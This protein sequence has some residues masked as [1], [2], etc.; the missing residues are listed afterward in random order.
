MT[1]FLLA[2][3]LALP[4][5]NPGQRVHDFANILSAS[6]EQRLEDLSREVDAATTAELAVVT[7]ASLEGMTVDDY[8]NSL[9]REWGIGKR[10]VNN[11]V[12]LIVAADE[13]RMKIEVGYGLEPLL[14]DG[15]AGEIADRAIVPRFKEGDMAGGVVAGAEKLAEILKASPDEARGVKG[16]APS[17]V[18][19]RGGV[20]PRTW[21]FV[22]IAAGLIFFILGEILSRSKRYPSWLFGAGALG[23][24]AT[25]LGDVFQTIQLP[26]HER[27]LGWLTGAGAVTLGAIIANARRYKRY[28]PHACPKCGTRLELLDEKKDD[29]HLTVAQKL[30]EELGSVDYDVWVCPACLEKDV[31]E[32]T[33]LFSGYSKCPKCSHRTYHEETT[34][35]KHA[36]EWSTGQRRIDG[37]CASCKYSGVRY[38]T[39]ARVVRSSS[40]GG[41]SSSGSGGGGSFGGGS[42]GGGG[43]SR[44]W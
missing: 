3:L 29:A 13:K 26:L 15:L 35:L 24:A 32:Y 27:S 14:T 41:G 16:S 44:G 23:C 33:A 40:S 5:P 2:F 30:E 38:E 1:P 9:F 7:V 12:L 28:G 22:A 31:A 37:R 20:N 6:Q 4:S 43:A 8:A 36:T 25:V 19:S 18:S 17:T 39:I 21:H 11:G 10:D 34:V 42:S